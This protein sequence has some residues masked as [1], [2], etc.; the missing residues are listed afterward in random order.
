MKNT[1]VIIVGGGMSG[2]CIG[3]YLSRA[4]VGVKIIEKAD[5]LGGLAGSVQISGICIDKYYHHLMHSDTDAL[6][7]IEDLGLTQTINWHT[8]AVSLFNGKRIYPFTTIKDILKLPIISFKERVKYLFGMIKILTSRKHHNLNTKSV[9]D[10]TRHIF[11]KRVSEKMW[12]PLMKNRWDGVTKDIPAVW[13]W[14]RIKKRMS[15]RSSLFGKETLG[16]PEGG[17]CRIIEALKDSV[18]S[19]GGQINTGDPVI[20]IEKNADYYEVFSE[21]GKSRCKIIILALPFPLVTKIKSNLDSIYETEKVPYLGTISLILITDKP[22]TKYYWTNIVDD[23]FPFC[24]VIDHSNFISPEKYNGK[25]I[26]YLVKYLPQADGFW[27]LNDTQI[28]EIFISY[29]KKMVPEFQETDIK[30][31][32]I[33]RNKATHAVRDYSFFKQIDRWLN[34]DQNFYIINDSLIY[35]DDRGV[36]VCVKAAKIILKKIVD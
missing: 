36:D 33:I 23:T 6:D 32:A 26:A 24:G 29:F 14:Q 31:Y 25:C 10:W 11:G 16:Y 3:Y 22:V 5:N 28:K 2:L 27:K 15:N 8:S 19:N 13:L 34:P 21:K 35:P 9:F 20:N 30:E 4:G 18:V 12:E 17:F 1:E 7:L